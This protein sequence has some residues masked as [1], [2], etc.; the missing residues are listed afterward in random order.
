MDYKSLV[1]QNKIEMKDL[2][3]TEDQDLSMYDIVQRKYDGWWTLVRI[4]NN[5]AHIITSGGDMRISF[6]FYSPN[7]ILL[8]EWM[9]GT[10]WSQKSPLK[11]RFL[12]FDF[13][14]ISNKDLRPYVYSDRMRE[15]FDWSMQYNSLGKFLMI[16]SCSAQDWLKE[17]NEA[18]IEDGFEGLV[19][20]NS[21]ESFS[22]KPTQ[23][24]MKRIFT[25]DYVVM[26]FKEGTG[27]LMGTLGALV[28]GK[29]NGAVLE[30][31]CTVGGG[32]SDILRNNIWSNKSFYCGKVFEAT[33]KGLFDSGALRHPAFSR[34]REDKL[35]E[36]CIR[37]V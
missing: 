33:G 22:L 10:N 5:V 20:K 32:F 16:A 21:K 26:D 7:A 8:C 23:G 14:E 2:N 24:R 3:P 31:I 27:R 17:W 15:Y 30:K 18:V 12:C 28:G 35:P 9:Y 37:N 11:D 1:L 4:E 19:F 34:F 25:E 13:L 29:Y 6:D 36:S